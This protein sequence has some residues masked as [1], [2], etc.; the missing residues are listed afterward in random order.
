MMPSLYSTAPVPRASGRWTLALL[1]VCTLALSGCANLLPKSRAEVSSPWDSYEQARATLQFIVPYKTTAAELKAQGIDP[2]VTPNVQVL[3]YSDILLRFP[4]TASL[5]PDHLDRGLRECLEAG[6]DCKG[7]TISVRDIKR[8]RVG[9]FWADALRFSRVVDVSGWT[10]DAI[11]LV[12]EGRVVYA[13]HGGQPLVK[14]RE[15]SRQPLGP[16]QNWGDSLGSA[17][18]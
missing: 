13:I 10:F 5:S 3:N 1:A 8:D 17:F 7:Y 4:V 15:T 18:R 6:D 11:V 9:N 16:L 2:Y 14:E 12:V